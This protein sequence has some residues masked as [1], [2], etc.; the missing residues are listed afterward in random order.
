M[1]ETVHQLYPHIFERDLP[2]L[3]SEAEAI[4]RC[5]YALHR[6]HDAVKVRIAKLDPDADQGKD[7]WIGQCRNCG[8]SLCS[9]CDWECSR[10]S[11][12]N[13]QDND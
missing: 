1:A 8:E 11:D 9:E 2:Q 5:L 12:S 13:W 6:E 10:C 7:H 4:Q 3:K